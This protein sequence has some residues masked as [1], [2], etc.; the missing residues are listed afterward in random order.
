MLQD[1]LP[2]PSSRS[3]NPKRFL[4]PEDWTDRLSQNISNKLPL[5]A[6]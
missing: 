3:K 5:L 6:A 1:N 2:V 4:N